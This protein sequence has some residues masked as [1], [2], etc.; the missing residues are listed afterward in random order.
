MTTDSETIPTPSRG[1]LFGARLREAGWGYAFVL[2][3]MNFA[4]ILLW[5]WQRSA[6]RKFLAGLGPTN[7]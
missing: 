1:S 6:D 4:L 2:L 7:Q 3:P 5:L